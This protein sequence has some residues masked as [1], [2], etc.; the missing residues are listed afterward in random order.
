MAE[1]GR[2]YEGRLEIRRLKRL[3]PLLESDAGSVDVELRFDID[4]MGIKYL[5]GKLEA[6]LILCCQRCL[7]A[8]EYPMES[9]FRLAILQS[10]AEAERIPET[11]EPLVVETTPLHLEEVLEDEILLSVPQIPMHDEMV[12]SLKTTEGKKELAEQPVKEEV[13]D[14]PFAVLEKLK[15]DH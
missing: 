4:E 14:N 6:K 11:Y 10:D 12:C 15:K 3:L 8:M 13:K 1:M 9:Q 7:E 2:Q 5:Q